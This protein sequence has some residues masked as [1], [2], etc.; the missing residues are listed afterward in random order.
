MTQTYGTYGRMESH[1]LTNSFKASS[2]DET[3]VQFDSVKLTT[4]DFLEVEK[5]RL[6][7]MILIQN[8]GFQINHFLK[9]D[10]QFQ[11]PREP[12]FTVFHAQIVDTITVSLA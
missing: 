11:Q 9:Y 7:E 12:D 10:E 2:S 1:N 4:T 6:H 5:V 3:V 8:D